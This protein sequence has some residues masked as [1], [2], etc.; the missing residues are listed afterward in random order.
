MSTDDYAPN[1]SLVQNYL[2]RATGEEE[3]FEGDW[4]AFLDDGTIP[5]VNILERQINY[6]NS[7]LGTSYAD[8]PGARAAWAAY[9]GVPRW[10]DIRML[11]PRAL[12][13][14]TDDLMWGTSKYL[15]WS[16]Y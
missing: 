9:H 14:G 13:W 12:I 6:I 3:A 16:T 15:N 5:G 11:T 4:H 1:Q 10:D 8:L 2:R 7:V